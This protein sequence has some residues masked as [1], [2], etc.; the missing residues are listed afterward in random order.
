[1]KKIVKI[2]GYNFELFT[3]GGKGRRKKNLTNLDKEI[4][5][6]L[7]K[8]G[9]SDQKISHFTKLDLSTAYINQNFRKEVE[10]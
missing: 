6:H 9:L 5:I 1:M 8:S 10:K 7:K 4:I 2:D 3:G